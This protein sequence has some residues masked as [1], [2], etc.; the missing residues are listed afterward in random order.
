VARS[1]NAVLEGSRQWSSFLWKVWQASFEARSVIFALLQLCTSQGI[2]DA[3]L[4]L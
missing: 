1:M 2:N 4:S 3:L